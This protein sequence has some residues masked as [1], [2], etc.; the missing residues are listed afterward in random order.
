MKEPVFR[1]DISGATSQVRELVSGIQHFPKQSSAAIAR[2]VNRTLE[3]VR[4]EAVRIGQQKY[5]AKT[6]SLR[7]RATIK[8]A[9]NDYPIGVLDVRGRKGLSLFN[10]RPSPRAVPNWKGVPVRKRRPK[11]GVSSLVKKGG[12]RKVYGGPGA[13]KPFLMKTD[14]GHT[15]IFVRRNKKIEMLY[16]P[17]PIQALGGQESR[18]RLQKKADETFTKRL[19]HEVERVVNTAFGK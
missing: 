6:E 19:Q 9:R 17:S 10:F 5:T 7:K 1:I 3:S 14:S 13:S 12:R 4:T 2:A 8:R 11:A 15:G 16:G 18:E